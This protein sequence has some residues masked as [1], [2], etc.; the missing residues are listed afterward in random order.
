M[1]STSNVIGNLRSRPEFRSDAWQRNGIASVRVTIEEPLRDRFTNMED[2]GRTGWRR[3]LAQ[4]F[5]R[6]DPGS[7]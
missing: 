6:R 7:Q 3:P 1:R 4:F 5:S 2:K